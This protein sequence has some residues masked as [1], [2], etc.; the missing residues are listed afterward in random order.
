MKIISFSLTSQLAALFAAALS[1]TAWAEDVSQHGD[2][3]Q[4]AI[5]SGDLEVLTRGP[6]HEAFATPILFEYAD[7]PATQETVPAPLNEAVPSF[8]PHGSVDAIWIP[9]YWAW[10][11]VNDSWSWVTGTWRVPP[12]GKR[13][14]S[15]YWTTSKN[16]SRWV[17]GFWSS[18][19][20]SQLTYTPA[21]PKPQREAGRSDLAAAEFWTPGTW[22]YEKGEFVWRSG[23]SHQVQP[24]WV[25]I[26]PQYHW[27]PG[28]YVFTSGYWDYPF[29]ER[30]WLFA[31]L[32]LTNPEP[33][34]RLT[35]R[36]NTL[37]K[38]ENVAFEL[39]ASPKRSTYYF[40]DFYGSGNVQHGFYP[41]YD[42]GRRGY[43]PIYTHQTWQHGRR[44]PNWLRDIKQSLRAQAI[45]PNRP[46]GGAIVSTNVDAG[47]DVLE[48][49]IPL[50]EF[51]SR[52]SSRERVRALS[53]GEQRQIIEQLEAGR[54]STGNRRLAEG[55]MQRSARAEVRPALISE[56]ANLND[57]R[58]EGQAIP[59]ERVPKRRPAPRGASRPT[60]AETAADAENGKL[61]VTDLVEL[62][63]VD[64]VDKDGFETK[65]AA[66][67][68]SV[69]THTRYPLLGM[70]AIAGAP[71]LH[72]SAI[73]GISGGSL[74]IY[75]GSPSSSG[76][77]FGGG[78]GGIGSAAGF[79][80][81][82]GTGTVYQ[83]G[84]PSAGINGLGGS[85]TLGSPG[86]GGGNFYGTAVS[87][88]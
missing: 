48:L 34:T 38:L 33:D 32:G 25:W 73:S 72:G 84:A 44:N 36:P 82:I 7:S 66:P 17:P 2:A 47:T 41:W 21:P 75:N 39:F 74:G 15:G 87:G 55:Q 3:A 80:P 9:G 26:S 40:G 60:T 20:N 6:F 18:A 19:K 8:R 27:S 4:R 50:K 63:A 62:D 67:G 77:A 11:D 10:N 45:N 35:V 28:G 57:R 64:A 22:L 81:N 31:P 88:S 52:E 30:G 58:S 69:T 37:L 42:Y 13:W 56:G 70:A 24:D 1:T 5:H 54:R 43:D 61:P 78:S 23:K 85:T 83:G 29:G 14:T 76:G 12:P 79:A 16:V 53:K 86:M 49:I 46:G 51:V 65:N 71:P 59:A 68:L